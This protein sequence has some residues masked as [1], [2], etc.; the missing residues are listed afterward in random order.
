MIVSCCVY[1]YPACLVF[2]TESYSSLLFV[3]PLW[4]SVFLPVI[5][6]FF[7]YELLKWFLT[8]AWTGFMIHRDPLK[9]LLDLPVSCVWYCDRRTPSI[10]RSSGMGF[11]GS[12]PTTERERKQ[13][14]GNSQAG[15][16]PPFMNIFQCFTLW[17]R[18][19]EET[20]AVNSLEHPS[21][22]HEQSFEGTHLGRFSETRGGHRRGGTTLHFGPS[23]TLDW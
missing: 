4:R 5:V 21:I 10:N 7:V 2:V 12:S 18:H 17:A 14:M 11:C 20:M 9:L 23:S 19:T 8:P 22:R 13:L 15:E 1:K 6:L 16:V 3:T